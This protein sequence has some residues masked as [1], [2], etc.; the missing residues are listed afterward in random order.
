M[1]PAACS[2]SKGDEEV[3]PARAAGDAG[4]RDAS[5]S[6]IQAENRANEKRWCGAAWKRGSVLHPVVEPSHAPVVGEVSI[7]RA[8]GNARAL[9]LSKPLQAR[10]GSAGVSRLCALGFLPM[11]GQQLLEAA[12]LI[13]TRSA[14]DQ[15]DEESAGSGRRAVAP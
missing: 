6:T 13:Q 4:V 14:V 3:S 5:V 9:T 8:I 7:T 12:L 1:A 10:S 15:V 2:C 11:P